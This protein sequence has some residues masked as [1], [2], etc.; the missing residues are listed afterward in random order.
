M[1]DIEVVSTAFDAILFA[2]DSTFITTINTSLTAK[3]LD[4]N[5]E[6]KMNIELEKIYDWLIVNKLSLNIKK[7]KYM[8]FHTINTKFTFVPKLVINSI[9]L[10]RVEN[11]N[12]L[13][14]TINE[15]LSW[16]PHMDKIANKISKSGGVINRMKHFLPTSILRMIYCSTIQ[17]NLMYS[18]LVWGYDCNR[19]VKIQKKIIRNICCEKFNA[20]TEPL[21][22]K[23]K[24]LKIGDLRVLNTLKFY[25]KFKKETVPEYFKSFKIQT[26]DEKHGRNT[27]YKSMISTN[28]TRLKLSDKCLRNNLPVVLNTTPQLALDKTQTH[29][30]NG[31][32]NYVKN[33][34]LESYANTC[35]TQNCYVCN[36]H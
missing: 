8:L 1:N 7:T 10:E 11:F 30:F 6:S 14:L 3:Q 16:K 28:F 29:S 21:L 25:Y 33:M 15:N 5:F 36:N 18:L 22:K 17:S 13:G 35:T 4:R 23:L 9:T 2:D 34:I 26:Q 19:L 32:G 12:F 27:R 31:F 24:L 20:H